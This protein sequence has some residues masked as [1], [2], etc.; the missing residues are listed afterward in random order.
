M[1]ARPG[2]LC[3]VLGV[4]TAPS[5]TLLLCIIAHLPA[6]SKCTYLGP[7]VF[8]APSPPSPRPWPS[9]SLFDLGC[10]LL[11]GPAL[12]GEVPEHGLSLDAQGQEQVGLEEELRRT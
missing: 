6:A 5:V 8:P 11:V 2:P 9:W 7:Q 3:W 1:R 4:L 12:L 10:P